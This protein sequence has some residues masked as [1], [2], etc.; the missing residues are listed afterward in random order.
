MIGLIVVTP[1][2][3]KNEASQAHSFGLFIILPTVDL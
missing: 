3:F 2:S 1:L